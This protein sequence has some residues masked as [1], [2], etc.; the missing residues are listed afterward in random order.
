MS[1]RRRHRRRHDGRR[2][3]AARR[4]AP[5][6]RRSWST[7]STAPSSAA[8][9][10][11][12]R[13]S[14]AGRRRAARSTRRCCTR[15]ARARRAA[16]TATSSSRPR[17]SGSSSSTSCSRRS[18]ARSSSDDCVLASNTSSIPITAIA[19]V[20][21]RPERVVG[22]HFFNPAPVMKLV[23]VIAGAGVLRG[24]AG[25]H[26]RAR[27]GDGQARRSTASDGPGFLVNRCNRPFGLEALRCLQERHRRRR[28]DRPHRPRRAAFAWARSSCRTSSGSTPASRSPS[29]SRELGFGE[30][31]WRPSPLSAQM[32]AAGR[33]GRKTGRGWY[34]YADGQPHRPDDPPPPSADPRPGA[35]RRRHPPRPLAPDCRGQTPQSG[36]PST[37]T[38]R[39]DGDLP[40][41]RLLDA[42]PLG[43]RSG[44]GFF[45]LPT[46]RRGRARRA[47]PDLAR[48]FFESLGRPV[49]D[50]EDCVGGV[51]GADGLPGHQRVALRA[52]RRASASPQDIDA[53]MELGHEPPAR[54]VRVD[55]GDRP[56]A[57]AADARRAAG[58]HAR[59]ALPRRAVAA[60]ARSPA[61]HLT[62]TREAIGSLYGRAPAL[63]ALPGG[64]PRRRV[65][66]PGRRGRADRRR[67]LLPGDLHGRDACL[68]RDCARLE[69]ARLGA[70]HRPPQG[71]RHLPLPQAPRRAR[72]GGARRSPTTTPTCP[73]TAVG[74]GPRAAA[75]AAR[76][77][78]A[79]LRRRPLPRRDRRRAR[80]QR[81]G[82][83]AL[84]ARGPQEAARGG[85]A[86]DPR[87]SAPA[88]PRRRR[89]RGRALRHPR[90]ARRRLRA[91]STRR[92]ARS[93]PR[94]R[95]RGLAC[96]A[97]DDL[98]GGL[99]A[100]ARARSAPACRRAS[101]RRRRASTRSAASSTS[102]SRA[103]ATTSTCRSTCRSIRTPFSKRLLA[104]HRA[105]P[106][107]RDPHLPR[108]G[109][110]R[111][112]RPP[113]SAPPAT[114]SAT[115]RSRSSCPATA[116]CAPAASIGGYTGGL[117]PQGQAARHRGRSSCSWSVSP[118]AAGTA[119]LQH[120]SHIRSVISE[121][122][123]ISRC[124]LRRHA[125]ARLRAAWT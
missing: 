82:R 57:G 118:S 75:Q 100:V 69:P 26:A 72:R 1:G 89:R 2:H 33:F 30:P 90:R 95:K 85:G 44:C 120:R 25:A 65:A 41:V 66:L 32:V 9:P 122:C 50:I 58:V 79:A 6:P 113:P 52:C 106:V 96:L 39:Y 115:T 10:A 124:A 54:A 59:G 45:A 86:H 121:R 7:R 116:C 70:D 43:G 64:P 13:A 24:G 71:A 101:S 20:A 110:R 92:S 117:R 17:P 60:P 18:R 29:P 68:S 4:W 63:P 87:P 48:Q 88:R 37:A 34:E 27:R 3:R 94:R 12:A 38:G 83:A 98:H 91:S 53:G 22:M 28:D 80:L 15:A 35:D 77:D 14:S 5:A 99:D 36:S 11:S 16:P 107:R 81:G 74:A 104:G 62:H 21:E 49:V 84:A 76:R 42:E 40:V 109:G 67:R 78:P 31:R 51:I 47:A 102:T 93:S 105:D 8:R 114:R 73:T 61:Q 111:R 97:Y 119:S 125:V 103:A 112:Q 55:G 46:G 56:G 19:R 108:H 23:E 123:A